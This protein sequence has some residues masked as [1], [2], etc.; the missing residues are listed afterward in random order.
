[1]KITNY[2]EN[3]LSSMTLSL[4]EGKKAKVI[5][6]E[7]NSVK[8]PLKVQQIQVDSVQLSAFSFF[9]WWSEHVLKLN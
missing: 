2:H 7:K 4:W 3:S 5:K 6:I 1:M 8:V 9:V